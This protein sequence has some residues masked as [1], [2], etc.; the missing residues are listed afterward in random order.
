MVVSNPSSLDDAVSSKVKFDNL[1]F[2]NLIIENRE[3]CFR[4]LGTS[5]ASTLNGRKM[6]ANMKIDLTNGNVTISN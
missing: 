5:P 2:N 1:N 3:F 6:L 4:D